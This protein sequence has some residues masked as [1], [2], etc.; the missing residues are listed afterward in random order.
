M[1]VSRGRYVLFYDGAG[2]VVLVLDRFF[3][4]AVAIPEISFRRIFSAKSVYPAIFAYLS[5]YRRYR[6][7]LICARGNDRVHRPRNKRTVSQ[8]VF[9]FAEM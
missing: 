8:A 2:S 5:I 7:Q 1:A 3:N 6:R 4:R 9:D